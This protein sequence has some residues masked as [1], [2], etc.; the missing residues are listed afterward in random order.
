MYGREEEWKNVN[1]LKDTREKRECSQFVITP[2]AHS[3]SLS[4]SRI[5]A[6]NA[7]PNRAFCGKQRAECGP[8]SREIT[9]V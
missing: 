2:S 7:P 8:V 4:L 6:K 3:L 9:K 5:C 1:R